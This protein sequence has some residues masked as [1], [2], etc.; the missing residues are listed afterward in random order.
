M[1]S[2]VNSIRNTLRKDGITGMDSINHCIVF[3]LC[4]LLTNEMCEK[5]GIDKKYSFKNIMLDEEGKELEAQEF[6]AKFY[7]KIGGNHFIHQVVNKLGF[8][9]IKFKLES[10]INLMEIIKEL[11]KLDIKKLSN[12][13]DIIGTIYELHL[14]SGTS[15]AMRDLGQYY[16]HRLVINYM[17][18]LCDPKMKKDGLIETIVDPTMGTGGFLTMSVKYLNDKYKNTIDWSKN[19]DNLYG[20]DIDDNVKNMAL[21]NL[22]LEMGEL[23][24]NTVVKQDTLHNDMKLK[25]DKIL[26]KADIILA[27]EPM[28]L[29]NI[30]HANCCSRIKEMKIRGTK[31]EPLF[32]QLFMEALADKGRCAVI[33]PDGVLFNESNQHI[34]TRKYLV[35][36]FNLK[37]VVTLNGDFFLNT[38]VKTS[39][40]FFTKDGN[41]T[42]EVDFCEIKIKDD[43]IEEN[44]IIKVSYN[45]IKKCNYSLFVNK[46]NV[47]DL[48]KIEG[49]EYKKLGDV[50]EFMTKSKRQ[51]SFGR[52]NGIY[53]F[54]TSSQ[55]VKWCNE[56]DYKDECIIIG[57]GGNANIKI[58]K[59]FS[60]STDNFILK[61][62]ENIKYLYYYLQ[63]NIN[64]LENGFSGST[65]KHISK[66]Y[67]KNIEIPIPPI[68]VQNAIVEKLD[69]LNSNIE[70]SKKMVEEYRKIIKYYVECQTRNE[71]EYNLG[72]I[73]ETESGD[74]IKSSDFKDGEYPV[75]GGGDASNYINKSNRRDTF[76]IAKDGV[77]EKCVRFIDGEFF[78]NHHGWTLNYK[79]NKLQLNKY[80]YY[81]LLTN[82][83]KLF[84]LAKGS[85]QKGINRTSFYSVIIQI[86]SIQ[87]QQEI[88]NYCD[89]LS[90]MINSIEKQ[91][92]DNKELMKKIMNSYLNNANITEQNEQEEQEEQ[93]DDN[94]YV[95]IKGIEYIKLNDEIY[96]I[97]EEGEP[98]KLF[99]T[100]TNEKFKYV[101]KSNDKI[102]VKGQNKVKNI[103]DLEA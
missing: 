22:L 6:K 92:I 10:P 95:V 69:V 55:T 68:A 37:K 35:E 67:I 54:Y 86:P 83:H 16:T 89:N 94:E 45:D 40:L 50:C 59:N 75:Y 84:A 65:I 1:E 79:N 46:Y 7:A 14:R 34:G 19:K 30:I 36:N 5:L 91:I 23:C 85:A 25:D 99:G 49:I 57:T 33:I 4:R 97:D 72:D 52:D 61:T 77:S 20:F 48:A 51:A 24:I 63:I 3:I 47:V 21:L 58:G 56:N 81:W 18:R 38:G 41:N 62:N 101:T 66:E 103:E 70:N 28:G 29:K 73:C 13:Y 15:N 26:E 90:S 39:V 93:E 98:D 32:L 31:A 17:I 8:K 44:S 88:V 76:V 60:C 11:K 82:E 100:Y 74:Y 12:K 9:N 64:I 80:M 2:I 43:D 78:L 42:N 102:I 71:K 27:N 87:K 53:H 96:T